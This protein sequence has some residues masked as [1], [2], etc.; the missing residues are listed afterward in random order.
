MKIAMIFGANGDA[1]KPRLMA[2]KDNLDIDTYN[3]LS[4]FLDIVQRNCMVYDR[5]VFSTSQFNRPEHL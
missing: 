2:Y 3:T 1:L 4:Q 5:I